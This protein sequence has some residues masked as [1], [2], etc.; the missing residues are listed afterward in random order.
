MKNNLIG[1]IC[2]ALVFLSLTP[3]DTRGQ[4]FMK[5]SVQQA[6]TDLKGGQEEF[7]SASLDR[8]LSSDPGAGA[9]SFTQAHTYPL[10]GLDTRFTA[11]AIARGQA[12]ESF[13]DRLVGLTTERIDAVRPLPDRDTLKA[14]IANLILMEIKKE[15][16]GDGK[17]HLKASV[18]TSPPLLAESIPPFLEHREAVREMISIRTG[19]RHAVKEIER[20]Q[21]EAAQSSPNTATAKSYQ[22]AVH[23]LIAAEWHEK[24]RHYGLIGKYDQAIEA[25]T[26]SIE[27]NASLPT[28]YH[29][30]GR[31]YQY[32]LKDPDRAVADYSAAIQLDGGKASYHSSRGLSLYT[33]GDFDDAQVDFERAI[34]LDP[35][36]VSA[37]IG[38]AKC[39]AQHGENRQAYRD[40][41]RAI[42]LDPESEQAL[43]GRAFISRALK[44]HRQSVEDFGAAVK[45]NPKNATAVYEQ[46]VGFAYLGNKAAVMRGFKE[47]A[48]LGHKK[49]QAFLTS[50]HIEW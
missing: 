23:R 30:R 3:A 33:S 9:Q 43:I 7:Q 50:K 36:H 18:H 20:M 5:K 47:A 44:D 10:S 42:A 49:A 34:E 48:K 25:Y 39:L 40:L 29:N 13:L 35:T 21:R 17:I 11:L 32:H 41:T 14:L 46:A 37:V 2:T 38:R 12:K 6:N 31:F 22:Q 4:A 1:C 16:W 27:Y 24:A 15:T 45:L 28:A 19:A 8:R 26:T